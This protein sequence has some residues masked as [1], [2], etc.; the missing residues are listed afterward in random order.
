L[1]K[2][3]NTSK[4]IPV[5]IASSTF[6]FHNQSNFNN[7][8]GLLAIA[9]SVLNF[10]DTSYLYAT[11]GPV[12]LQISQIVVGNNVNSAAAGSIA[13]NPTES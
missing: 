1:T 9:A 3:F 7:N 8:S 13:Q 5:S 10:Y 2:F 4:S 12:N 11:G 6:T